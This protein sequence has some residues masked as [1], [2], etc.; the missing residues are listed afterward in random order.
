MKTG[1]TLLVNRTCRLHLTLS[2]LIRRYNHTMTAVSY[3]PPPADLFTTNNYINSQAKSGQLHLAN[4]M[5]DKMPQRNAVSWTVLISGYAQH[6]KSDQCFRLFGQMIFHFRPNDFAYASV[7]SVC[8]RPR[9]LQVHGLILKTGFGSWIYVANSL[10]AMYWKNSRDSGSEAWRVFESMGYCN[11]VTYNSMISG[12][13][14]H[15]KGDRAMDLFIRMHHDGV[16]F[17]RATLLALVSSLCGSNEGGDRIVGLTCCLQLHSCGIK[18]GLVL[19]VGVKTAL[20]KGYSALASEFSGCL[21]LFMETSGIDRDIVLWTG[22]MTACAEWEPQQALIFFSQMRREDLSPDC[23]VFSVML[24]ACANLVTGRTT[25]SFHCQVI[26]TGFTNVIELGN[27]LIHA[28][29]RCG[30]IYCA[31]KVFGEMPKRDIVS[32]NSILKAYAVHGKAEKALDSFREMDVGPDGTTFV[33]L[34]SSCSHAGMVKQGK[35]LFDAMKR[36]YGVVPQLDHYAC[37]VD[38]LGRAGHVSEAERIIREMP[39]RPDYVI[40]SAFLGACRKYGDARAAS[41]ASS[42][43]KELDPENSLGYVL[44]SNIYCLFRNYDEGG[45]LRIKMDRIGVRKEP[46][47]SWTEVG[48]RV[49]E[50]ACGG[51]RHPQIRE[52]RANMEVLLRDLR[53]IGYAPETSLV[54]FD[55]EE[56]HKEEQLYQHSEKLALVFSLTSAG[57]SNRNGDVIKIIKNIRICLDCHNFMKF[58]S[59]LVRKSYNGKSVTTDDFSIEKNS[60]LGASIEHASEI[61]ATDWTVFGADGSIN[62]A[63]CAFCQTMLNAGSWWK[64]RGDRTNTKHCR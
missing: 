39:M 8:D 35:N 18:T 59:K 29:S 52:I 7:L 56:E 60:K 44:A 23:Y 30:S 43:L 34:L 62:T 58:A 19:D 46:G 48:H 20:I 9:G 11:L 17:D 10:V 55:V 51:H 6:G 28:Y 3:T 57:N 1:L 26:I 41:L 4:K 37:M 25:S 38:I 21:K 14:M 22:I 53:K 36:N 40:W 5:F 45:S 50:F 47:L 13:G 63:K 15:G 27:A 16:K 33:A 49:H 54:L 24:K 61:T 31:E 42:N 32:W 64:M 12:L 2:Q